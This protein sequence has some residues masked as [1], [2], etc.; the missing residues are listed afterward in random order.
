MQVWL[1]L[2]QLILGY[3]SLDILS[4]SFPGLSQ[5]IK[6][7]PGYPGKGLDILT[8]PGCRFSRWTNMFKLDPGP[9]RP[10]P[11]AGLVP[12]VIWTVLTAGQTRSRSS[13]S[14]RPGKRCSAGGRSL[15]HWQRHTWPG[16]HGG[17]RPRSRGGA[18]QLYYHD[19]S[20]R[21]P[22]HTTRAPPLV[23]SNWVSNWRPTASRSM[24]F[25]KWTRHP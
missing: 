2:S 5:S 21:I 23:G 16:P 24:P 10:R 11:P 13:G 19:C 9:R 7:I 25:P 18:Q 14:A 3:A 12:P 22:G 6:S 17:R 4:P 1:V 8:C 15:L 20:G